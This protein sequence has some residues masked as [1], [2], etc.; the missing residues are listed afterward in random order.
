VKKPSDMI[1]ICDVPAVP[2]NVLPSFN[3]NCEP[4]DVRRSVA[5]LLAR[6]TATITAP[7]FCFVTD[8]WKR[9]NE[10]TC[11]TQIMPTGRGRW[12]I[13]NDP[14]FEAGYWQSSPSWINTLDQ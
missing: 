6:P 4:A 13:D 7:T 10:T 11:A 1:W 14:H 2:Q 3:G 8:M 9:Q 5:I 12:N